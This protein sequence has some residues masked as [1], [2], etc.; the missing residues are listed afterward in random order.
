MNHR[1]DKHI[2]KTDV[3]D[4]NSL[5]RLTRKTINLLSILQLRFLTEMFGQQFFDKG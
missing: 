2:V 5:L 1:L 4:R 3:T